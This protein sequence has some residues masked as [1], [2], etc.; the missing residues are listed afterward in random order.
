MREQA[1]SRMA[2]ACAV[3][4]LALAA[5]MVTKGDSVHALDH[6]LAAAG[7]HLDTFAKV[8]P[9]PTD[10]GSII[11]ECVANRPDAGGSEL[12][13]N[14]TMASVPRYPLGP[15]KCWPPNLG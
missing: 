4:V 12:E 13:P 2:R 3:V 6:G 14:G 9:D 7:R 10:D 1:R 11:I 5:L 8:E 15:S